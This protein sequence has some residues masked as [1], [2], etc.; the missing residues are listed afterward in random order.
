MTT[1]TV[2]N[3]YRSVINLNAECQC[4]IEGSEFSDGSQRKRLCQSSG[5]EGRAEFRAGNF[6]IF[7]FVGF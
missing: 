1:E 7:N 2:Q 3:T 6:L 4:K 5:W